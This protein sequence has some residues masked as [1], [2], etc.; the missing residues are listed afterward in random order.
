MVIV[1]KLTLNIAEHFFIQ[2]FT[3]IYMVHIYYIDN[4][5]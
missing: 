3:T 5:T 2:H 4:E 1:H